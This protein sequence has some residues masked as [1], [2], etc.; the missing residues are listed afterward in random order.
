MSEYTVFMKRDFYRWGWSKWAALGVVAGL[1]SFV[2]LTAMAEGRETLNFNPDWKFIKADATNAFQP[3]FNDAAWTTVSAPHTFNDTDTFNHWSLPGHR[4]EQQ[5]WS[6]RTWYRKT[7]TAP[8]SFKGKKIYIEFE[9]VRQV[10]EVYLNGKFLGVSKTGFTPFGFDLTPYL[11]FD[12]PNVLAVMCDNRFMKDPISADEMPGAGGKSE[13][14]DVNLGELSAKVNATIPDDVAKIEA[15]Q[16]PWNNPHWHPAHGGIFRNV[17]VYVT[18][19]LHVSLPLYSFLQT[20]GPYIYETGISRGAAVVNLE[21]PVENGRAS[22]ETVTV[23]AEIFDQ[24]DRPVLALEQDGV[25]AAGGR[26]KFKLTGVLTHPKL[27]EPDYPQLY[28]AVISVVA[29][30]RTVDQT[31]IPFGIR[32]VRWDTQAGF[33]HQRPKHLKLH[34]WGQK[35]TDEW[36]GLGAAQPDWLHF[37]TLDLMHEAGGNFVRWGHCVCGP[38]MADATDR[39]GMVVEP[40]QRGRRVGHTRRGMDIA[41]GGVA[42]CADLL[43]QSSLDFNLGGRQPESHA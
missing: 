36:P 29:G 19:P 21:V 6:G 3:E 7:F 2:A 11:R 27:W 39:L 30:G 28:R 9:A 25:M 26:S 41:D 18:D 20:E 40:S 15:D 23:R 17:H 5:Q 22:G 37:Y 24:G 34:G 12:G 8:V 32:D 42:R 35:P 38:G 43:S 16:I 10:A 31:E 13:A 4:G 1:L 14:K 33:S